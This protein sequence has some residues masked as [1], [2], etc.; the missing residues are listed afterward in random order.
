MARC[1]F[2]IAVPVL[3]W[4]SRAH[5]NWNPF[6]QTPMSVHSKRRQKSLKAAAA[7]E[8][9]GILHT[10][11]GGEPD[12]VRAIGDFFWHSSTLVATYNT[13]HCAI[14][15]YKRGKQLPNESLKE[16]VTLKTGTNPT[17]PCNGGLMWLGSTAR[18]D[19]CL[20]RCCSCFGMLADMYHWKGCVNVWCGCGMFWFC[21]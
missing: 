2:G 9:F 12:L 10:S 20:A 4:S 21:A 7:S 3:Q 16:G 5:G 13:P 15:G 6:S 17:A 8:T 19:P 11:L 18:R 14:K 1:C